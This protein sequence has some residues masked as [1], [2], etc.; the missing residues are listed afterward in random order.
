[1]RENSV[2]DKL[3]YYSLLQKLEK[4]QTKMLE[5]NCE[6]YLKSYKKNIREIKDEVNY[7]ITQCIHS[8][9]ENSLFSLITEVKF[10]IFNF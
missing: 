5:E 4:L 1:M 6:K 9:D 8:I 3:S 10:L 7:D 2:V